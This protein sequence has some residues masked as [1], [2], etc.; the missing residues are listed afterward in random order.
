MHRQLKAANLTQTP[1][2]LLRNNVGV[3]K[4][5]SKDGKKVRYIKYGLCVGSSDLIG[6]TTITIT[7][8]M[9]GRQAAIFTAPEVKKPGETPSKKQEKF[10]SAVKRAGGISCSAITIDDVKYAIEEWRR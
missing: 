9:V 2:I 5:K 3:A 1:C 7:P 6:W 10:L 4:V 8:D